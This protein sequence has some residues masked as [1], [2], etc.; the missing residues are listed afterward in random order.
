MDGGIVRKLAA[1]RWVATSIVGLVVLV[2]VIVLWHCQVDRARQRAQ[3][4]ER[5][6]RLATLRAQDEAQRM[7]VERQTT[8]VKAVERVSQLYREIDNLTQLADHVQTSLQRRS[9]VLKETDA[10]PRVTP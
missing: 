8:E 6:A 3:D 2:S 1:S 4:T 7:E 10:K 5:E 9:R